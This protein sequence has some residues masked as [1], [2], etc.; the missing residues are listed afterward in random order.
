MKARCTTMVAAMLLGLA[1]FAYSQGMG[2]DMDK[3]AT[4]L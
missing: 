2:S 3:A 1:S 4:K